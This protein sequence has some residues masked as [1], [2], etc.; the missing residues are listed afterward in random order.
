MSSAA[1][2]PGGPPAA[3]AAKRRQQDDD[4]GNFD[5][6]EMIDMELGD[7][8]PPEGP[9]CDEEEGTFM[10]L[11]E[12][13]MSRSQK[14]AR[15]PVM[16]LAPATQALSIQNFEADYRID[17]PIRE[18]GAGSCEAK[19]AVV[20]LYGVT[21]EG[22]SVLI[23][24]HGFLPYF[25]APAWPK[26]EPSQAG[27]FFNLLNNKVRANMGRDAVTNPV[28]KV[29]IE[30]KQSLMHFAQGGGTFL[31]ITMALPTLIPTARRIL[32]NGM[33]LPG[34]SYGI[35]FTTFESNFPFV[36]RF[37]VDIELQGCA[38]VSAKEGAYRVRP[39]NSH[40]GQTLNRTST[41]QIE[42]DVHYTQLVAHVPEGDWLKIAPFSVL[43]VDIECAGRPGV[44]PEAEK[45]P[46]IQIANHVTLHGES[47]P[48]LRC[49][50]TL[51]HCAPIADAELPSHPPSDILTGYNT[52]NFDLPY[53]L[54]RAQTLGVKTF[55]LLGRI[56][57]SQSVVKDKTFSSKAV[58]TRESKEVSMD[59]RVQLD[60]LQVMQTNY[61]LRS[62]S[63][64]AVSA[65]FLGEQK[66]DVHYS[67]ISELQNGNAD[68][69]RRLAVYCLKDAF[70]P[71]RLID[72]LMLMI[73]NIEMVRVTGVRLN[74]HLQRGQQIKVLT[75]LYR[76]ARTVGMVIPVMKREGGAG[77]GE[78]G[79][80]G[81]TVI[82]PIK[83]Y[84]DVPIA[85]LD[86]A[87]LYPSIMMAHNTCYS[88]LVRREEVARLGPDVKWAKSP[89][90]DVFITAE[91]RKGL[92]PE[93]LEELLSARKRAK[94]EMKK[95]TDPLTYAVLDGR[96][97]ALKISAN[98]VYGFTG[99]TVGQLPCLEISS[100]VTAYGREMIEKTK[101]EVERIY[102]VANGYEHDVQVVY[103]DTDSV[104]IKFG[105]KD[106]G[107]AMRLGEEAAAKV[108]SVFIKPIKL[109]FEKCYFPYLLM[110]KKRYAGL[111]WTNTLK[112]DKMD[113]KGIE[114]VRRDNCSLVKE[115]MDNCLRL[116]LI[117]QNVQ[118]AVSYVKGVI[119]DLL[120]N[121]VDLS[122]L[123]ISKAL[124]RAAD[125]YDNKQAHV[126]LAARI[127]KRDPGMA[128]NIGDR[129]PY[130]II[131]GH[132][133]AKAYEKSEDP[134]YVLENNIPIDT[135]HYL[136][137]QL[138]EP[139][140]RLFEPI[141]EH[142]ERSLLEGEHTRSIAKPTPTTGGLMKF[143]KVTLQ[144]LGCKTPLPPGA[145][146][147]CKSCVEKAPEIFSQKLDT[148]NMCENAFNRLWTQCQRCQGDMHKDVLCTSRDCPIYY[149]RKKIQ[150]DLS[151]ATDI[152]QRFG[153]PAW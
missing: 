60:V 51:N 142:P 133:G 48:K 118:G 24:A 41:C 18:L 75:Q 42:V 126:D 39:W 25:Y 123:V 134:I 16:G 81:A 88:T 148:V 87:S 147:V 95:T 64:N 96:Q 86:F 82:P 37:M 29:E 13:F 31:K 57:G 52:L 21:A 92:L 90:G 143:A 45:D 107:E 36:L 138:A 10:T 130:V 116:I 131:K 33:E 83:G 35:H 15:P 34:H 59:G 146:S 32:E 101:S 65:H 114:S 112:Y 46:I 28:L 105:T 77:N 117:E 5:E 125:Q 80:E 129:I 69:R 139:L 76:K 122:L 63:L 79:F 121:R 110:N 58:G 11:G 84:Y 119:S 19:V 27:A 150:K 98:S 78:I 152:V 124:T 68:T 8:G 70:L 40:D 30:H 153:A 26:F 1:K 108:T 106:L 72:K 137:H 120:M 43:S 47:T 115:M 94:A 55:P 20:R 149:R 3:G 62:Y 140:K 9:L 4:D 151:D 93:I 104:M 14:W 74:D 12:H 97:L 89:S 23:H 127:A 136:E 109:E 102:T 67:I 141:L 61:K 132:K 73:N 54:K 53:L 128:P 44:F 50:L 49:I 2:R 66:E 100:S 111:L 135:Q 71:Q 38:W 56:R 6:D 113:C 17:A 91:T 85:T 144:C 145:T 22:H 99:A 103:G 7:D